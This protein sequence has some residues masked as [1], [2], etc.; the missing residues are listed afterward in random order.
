MVNHGG[1]V[2][3]VT[4]QSAFAGYAE[5]IA[6]DA[7]LGRLLGDFDDISEYGA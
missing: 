3:V 7:W 1:L 6:D 5:Y 4:R 2:E